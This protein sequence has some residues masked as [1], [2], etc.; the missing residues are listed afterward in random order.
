M[1]EGCHGPRPLAPPEDLY[2]TAGAIRIFGVITARPLNCPGLPKMQIIQVDAFTDRPFAGNP[3]AVCILEEPRDAGWM[4]RVASEMNLSETA[5][6][7]PEKPDGDFGLRW[8]TPSVE[9]DLCGHA[10]LATAHV[11]RERG[12]DGRSRFHTRSGVLT[13]WTEDGWIVM[14]FPARPAEAAAPPAGL[15]DVLPA[16]PVFVGRVGTDYLVALPSAHLVRSMRPDVTQVG[17]IEAR[18]LIVTAPSDR[19]EYDFVSRFFAPR[20]GIPEDPVTGAAHCCLAPYW[21][22]RLGKSSM[23]GFQA[24]A[25]GGEVRVTLQGDRVLLA[26]QAVTVLRGELVE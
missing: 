26:G 20:M 22:A 1:G 15:F 24:S 9:V 3:A 8:F 13:T 5:F 2:R 19:P 17:R 25:R 4:Q 12:F 10:T 14:D 23:V 7:V 18:G 6:V 11:L 16:K 21:A